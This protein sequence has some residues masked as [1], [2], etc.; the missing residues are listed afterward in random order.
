VGLSEN[1]LLIVL[2]DLSMLIIIAPLVPAIGLLTVLNGIIFITPVDKVIYIYI[3]IYHNTPVITGYRA[4]NC[5]TWLW[6]KP[7]ATKPS[8]VRRRCRKLFWPESMAL[9]ML[10][11]R[12]WRRVPRC[13]EVHGP[14]NHDR[15]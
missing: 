1:R 13:E 2:N 15:K 12:S 7:C 3:Y 4:N 14:L 9:E 11:K 10:H 8:L 6:R 5:M